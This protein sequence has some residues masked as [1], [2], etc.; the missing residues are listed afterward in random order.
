MTG[1]SLLGGIEGRLGIERVEY[2][3]DEQCVHAALQ[4]CFHLLAIGTDQIVKSKGAQR[5]VVYIGTHGAGLVCRTY[6][7]GHEAWFQGIACC[8]LVGQSS[9]QACGFQVHLAAICLQMIIRHGNPLGIKGIGLNDISTG[10]QI[11]AMYFLDDMR[12]RQSQQIVVTL[13]LAGQ[14]GKTG[15]AIVCFLQP[16]ALYHGAHRTVQYQDTLPNE[17][18]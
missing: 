9:G 17:F 7:T 5:G 14:R 10:L 6:G 8:V 16:I 3:F 1:K 11:L 12:G 4:Q 13:L 18:M 15:A 2:G